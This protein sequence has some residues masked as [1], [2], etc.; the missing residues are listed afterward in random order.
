M[1]GPGDAA[2]DIIKRPVGA[3]DVEPGARTFLFEKDGRYGTYYYYAE[4]LPFWERTGECWTNVQVVKLTVKGETLVDAEALVPQER[5][6]PDSKYEKCPRLRVKLPRIGSSGTCYPPAGTRKK[7][8]C[9]YLHRIAAYAFPPEGRARER[10]GSWFDFLAKEYQGDHLADADLVSRPNLVIAGWVDPVLPA[11]HARREA[12]RRELRTAMAVAQEVHERRTQGP[13]RLSALEEKIQGLE[14]LPRRA[15][16]KRKAELRE[17]REERKR[18]QVAVT[19]ARALHLRSVSEPAP[20]LSWTT[21]GESK[22]IVEDATMDKFIVEFDKQQRLEYPGD[23]KR[24][25][26]FELC[27]QHQLAKLRVPLAEMRSRSSL[28]PPAAGEGRARLDRFL[29]ERK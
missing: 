18:L 3:R 16:K 26:L 19:E 28:P 10:F 24:A 14:E 8:S 20:V 27:R 7:S 6:P 17:L 11:V 5:V 22:S 1:A 29:A 2:G 9:E 21:G 13:E 15:S 25:E 4:V 23:P 12:A